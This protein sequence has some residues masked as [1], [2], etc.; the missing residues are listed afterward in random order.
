M[1]FFYKL[2]INHTSKLASEMISTVRKNNFGFRG[3]FYLTRENM[4]I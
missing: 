1:I 2:Q 4:V 3:I